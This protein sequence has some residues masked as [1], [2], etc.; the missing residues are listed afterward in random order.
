MA[1]ALPDHAPDGPALDGTLAVTITPDSHLGRIMDREVITEAYTC[2]Y[3]LNPEFATA[4]TAKGLHV[5]GVDATGAVRAVELPNH[6]F[7]IATLYQPQR[8]SAEGHPHP[9]IMAYLR[10][11]LYHHGGRA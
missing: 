8:A 2:N 5:V 11:A 6:P 10:A 1:C 9:L 4:L 3:E 7:F